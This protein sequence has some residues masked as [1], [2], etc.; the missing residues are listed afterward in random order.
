MSLCSVLSLSFAWSHIDKNDRWSKFF[1]AL[2]SSILFLHVMSVDFS[3]N[4]L[5][6][7]AV[8]YAWKC[9]QKRDGVAWDIVLQW[10]TRLSSTFSTCSQLGGQNL[11]RHASRQPS[12]FGID[13]VVRESRELRDGLETTSVDLNDSF[14]L[15]LHGYSYLCR[16]LDMLVTI[17]KNNF[18]DPLKHESVES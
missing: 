9:S 11:Q 12:C 17:W 4:I 8:A 1:V 15:S 16:T 3:Y 13:E 6:S 10:L 14:S 5:S 2:R 18:D 7:V